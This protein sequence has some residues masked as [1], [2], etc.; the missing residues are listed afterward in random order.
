MFVHS[1]SGSGHGEPALC[2]GDLIGPEGDNVGGV[3]MLE[4]GL[5]RILGSG[6]QGGEGASRKQGPLGRIT[7]MAKSVLQEGLTPEQVALTVCLGCAVGT[8]PFLCGTTLVCACLAAYLGLNQAAMQAVNYLVYPLQLALMVPF[9]RLGERFLPWG[10][11]VSTDIFHRALHGHF[12]SALNL[13]GWATLKA[14]GAW[15][16]T[17]PPLALLLY[18]SSLAVLRRRKVR[19]AP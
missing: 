12:L 17:V 19:V 1:G 3:R 8:L 2:T 6:S 11:R 14:S 15:L 16:V 13:I 7:G 18:V 10:P 9:A 5:K 4:S